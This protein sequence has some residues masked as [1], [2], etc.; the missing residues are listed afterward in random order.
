M[1]RAKFL[2]TLRA[3]AVKLVP[4]TPPGFPE[5]VYLKAPTMADV[6]EQILRAE[7]LGDT[8]KERIAND[9]LYL[10]R[11]LARILRNADGSLMFDAEDNAQLAELKAVL[12]LAPHNTSR[13]IHEAHDALSEPAKS[14]ETPKGN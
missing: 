6:K 5:P 14:E 13:L 3:G 8:A 11:S 12:D 10:E 2:E 4:F 9:P 1:D 7:V